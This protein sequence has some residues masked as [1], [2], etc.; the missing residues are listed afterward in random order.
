MKKKNGPIPDIYLINLIKIKS[1]GPIQ[2]I[3][4]EKE[5]RTKNNLL[6]SELKFLSSKS[7]YFQL[8]HRLAKM[9]K[10]KL[11]KQKLEDKSKKKTNK[12]NLNKVFKKMKGSSNKMILD[13]I[14]NNPKIKNKFLPYNKT[15]FS[16]D[17]KNDKY[18]PKL[19]ID[20]NNTVPELKYKLKQCHTDNINLLSS[21]NFYK[22]S[23][24]SLSVLSSRNQDL[25]FKNR[26]LRI[27]S[28]NTVEKN[29]FYRSHDYI[30]ENKYKET[31]DEITGMLSINYNIY[32]NKN[33][34]N[35]IKNH[36]SYF[37]YKNNIKL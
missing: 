28:K 14:Y 29:N 10:E 12:N 11:K 5:Y 25:I 9:N 35:N 32:K 15:N 31:E 20:S 16:N 7:S 26:F 4:I 33:N 8:L 3:N 36:Y 1:R 2:P 24:N 22:N 18:I 17:I 13:F 19:K 27:K 6:R 30:K 23:K 34:N 37:K 21:E